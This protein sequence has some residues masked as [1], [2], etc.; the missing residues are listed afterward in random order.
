MFTAD[1]RVA[2]PF[3]TASD[4]LGFHAFFKTRADAEAFAA[5][6]GGTLHETTPGVVWRITRPACDYCSNA[7][8]HLIPG[9]AHACESCFYTL[10]SDDCPHH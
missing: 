8:G 7:A 2:T 6:A 5:A 4:W 3:F 9:G 1:G 10:D